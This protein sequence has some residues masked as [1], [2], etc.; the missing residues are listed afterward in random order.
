MSKFNFVPAKD[1][2]GNVIPG[3]EVANFSAT[4]ISIGDKVL[5]NVNGTQYR[6]GTIEFED[7]KDQK[8]RVSAIVYEKNYEHG[9]ETGETFLARVLI[10]PNQAPLITLSHLEGGGERATLDMFGKEQTV[11]ANPLRPETV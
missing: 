8:Q 3:S 4:L 10:Q 2:E 9:M 7:A 1:A 5:E 6:V 11:A